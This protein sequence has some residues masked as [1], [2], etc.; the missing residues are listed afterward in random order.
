MT[1]ATTGG[2]RPPESEQETLGLLESSGALLSGHFLLS[3]GL[4]SPRYLQCAAALQHPATAEALGTALA[5]RWLEL[6]LPPVE[7]VVS[8]ALGGII[9]GH[10]VGRALGRRAFFTER[11][12]GIVTL[13]RGFR[14][15]PGERVL[16]VEDVVTTG[17]SI[18]ETLEVIEAS[19]GRPLGVA[20]IANRGRD[21]RPGG[22]PLVHLVAL[23][24]PAYEPVACPDCEAGSP[25]VKPGSRS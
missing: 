3:S 5:H 13:R 12:D 15:D 21:V 9:I 20:C 24:F 23:D 19:G 18:Q 17:R 10:E 6:E 14:V 25:A 8:P 4:H 11:A 22:L 16:V 7:A 2:P 1:E